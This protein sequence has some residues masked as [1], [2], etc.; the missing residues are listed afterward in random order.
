MQFNINSVLIVWGNM[1]REKG[2]KGYPTMESFMRESPREQG[3]IMRLDDST[4]FTIDGLFIQLYEREP[5]QYQI[6][7]DKYIRRLENREIC[8][9]LHIGKSQFDLAL[10][11]AKSFIAG[12]ITAK[13]IQIWL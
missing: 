1:A 6:L 12:G 5:L 11:C 2:C 7:R 9:Q 3:G 13:A 10:A 8:R 4:F